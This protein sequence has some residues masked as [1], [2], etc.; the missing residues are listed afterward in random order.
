M[1]TFQSMTQVTLWITGMVFV[2]LIAALRTNPFRVAG[3]FVQELFTSRKYLLHFVAVLAILFFNKIEQWVEGRMNAQP[4]FTS[5]IYRLEGNLVASIQH[6]FK[7]DL[8]TDF[9]SF[10]YLVVFPALMI[11]SIGIYTYSRDFKLF[12][13]VCYALM[14]NYMIAIPFYLFLPV[15]EVWFFHPDVDLLMHRVFPTFE[16]EYR[17]LSGLD[18]CFPSLHTAISVSMAVI[19][20]RSNNGFWKWFTLGSAIIIIFSI[21]YLG[22]HW[23]MD[24]GA[25]LVLGLFAARMGLRLSELHTVPNGYLNE[26]S[27]LKG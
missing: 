2:L 10:F 15:N 12:H 27:R 21:F 6:F 19:A 1:I 23:M 14:F 3:S 22:V 25:G 26:G 16:Q 5:S 8:L 7:N 24:M 20:A 9:T 11:V 17:P 4:D 18:N 13:A